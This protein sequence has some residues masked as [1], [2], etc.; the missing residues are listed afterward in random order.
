MFLL[1]FDFLFAYWLIVDF[2]GFDLCLL[3]N[4]CCRVGDLFGCGFVVGCL[5]WC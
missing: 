3:L 5:S 4:Y 2:D 1:C